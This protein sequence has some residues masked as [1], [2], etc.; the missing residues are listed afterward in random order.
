MSKFIFA[1]CFLFSALWAQNFT[2]SLEERVT[3]LENQMNAKNFVK[4]DM[5]WNQVGF[6]TAD[7]LCWLP[8]EDGLAY[9]TSVTPIGPEKKGKVKN[10]DFEWTS[11]FRLG[12]GYRMPH[13]DW[14]LYADWTHFITSASSHT[15]STNDFIYPEWT[16]NIVPDLGPLVT[17]MNGRWNMHLNV[18][19]G[20]MARYFLVTN[21]LSLRPHIGVQGAWIKQEYNSDTSGGTDATSLF[22]IVNDN[23]RIKNDFIGAGLAAGLD[24]EWTMWKHWNIFGNATFSLIYGRFDVRQIETQS[25]TQN[26]SSQMLS[27]VTNKFHTILPTADIVLGVS[28]DYSFRYVAFRLEAGWEYAAFFGQ[29]QFR[30]VIN[31]TNSLAFTTANQSLTMQG[32]TLSG[33]F[34]F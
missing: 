31:P 22:T 33:R 29:N 7:Y 11:G 30:H 18:V 17:Y 4:P 3:E 28:Y 13:D 16:P 5:K 10:L 12:A 20:E 24:T 15:T 9:A 34:D 8:Q 25:T 23:F 26:L 21:N 14:E 1:S 6:L 19:E 27:N 32:F 2:P